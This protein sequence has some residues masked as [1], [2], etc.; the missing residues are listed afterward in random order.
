MSPGALLPSWSPKVEERAAE[1]V[2]AAEALYIEGRSYDGFSPQGGNALVTHGMF[3]YQVVP[4][5]E[6]VYVLQVT[7]W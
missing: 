2:R 3:V 1:L 7:A 4:R 5:Q 6:R